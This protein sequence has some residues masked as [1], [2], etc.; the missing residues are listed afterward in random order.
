[1]SA[2]DKR[3]DIECENGGLCY[4]QDNA[5]ICEC[6]GTGHTGELCHQGEIITTVVVICYDVT[7]I[8]ISA[9][10]ADSVR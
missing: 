2:P 7:T 1:M 3:C 6:T 8:Q 10:M 5:E 9:T 4:I